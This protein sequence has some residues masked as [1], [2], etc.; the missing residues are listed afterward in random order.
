MVV[1]ITGVLNKTI[2]SNPP[3]LLAL[4]QRIHQD[5]ELKILNEHI[6]SS[7]SKLT[8]NSSFS[9]DDCYNIY[10]YTLSRCHLRYF[11]WNLKPNEMVTCNILF[12]VVRSGE[13]SAEKRLR[14]LER[15]EE[16][17]SLSSMEEDFK[18]SKAGVKKICDRRV[19]TIMFVHEIKRNP[20]ITIREIK[21]TFRTANRANTN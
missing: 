1:P 3:I 15:R 21:K 6:L 18:L 2:V 11:Y 16:G 4:Q 5:I 9:V 13:R 20:F 17:C 7:E 8:S 14:I 19:E 10:S 12:S